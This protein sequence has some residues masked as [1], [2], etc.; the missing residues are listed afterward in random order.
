MMKRVGVALSTLG[1][2]LG[3]ASADPAVSGQESV[4]DSASRI[5]RADTED[6]PKAAVA[7]VGL[8]SLGGRR[9]CSGVYVAPRVVITAAHCL[10]DIVERTIVYFGADVTVD[11]DQFYNDDDSSKPWVVA[12]TWASHPDYDANLHF[13]DLAAVYLPRALPFEPAELLRSPLR[14]GDVDK[15]MTIS[16]WGASKALTPDLSELEGV[17]VQRT[18]KFPFLGSPTVNDF[19]PA[20][21][22]NGLF[23]PAIRARL[24]KFDGRAPESNSC[25]GDSGAPIFVKR[26]GKSYVAAINFFTGLSCEGYSMATRVEPFLRYFDDVIEKGGALAVEPKLRCVDQAADGTYTAFFGYENPNVIAVDIALGKNNKLRED[27]FG[28][29]PTRFL[30]GDHPWDFFLQFGRKERLEYEL[31]SGGDSC[32]ER[33]E[34]AVATSRSPRCDANAP[35]VSCAQLCK[36]LSACD[37]DF[38]DCMSDC[39]SNIPFF[40]QELPQCLAPWAA[41]NR[42]MA[43]LPTEDLCN[44]NSPPSCV[45]EMDAYN[46]CFE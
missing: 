15:D 14:N 20:D 26:G 38:G 45:T 2:A 1:C 33:H 17:G 8:T 41:L 29:R 6:G 40:Q 4:G 13:P 3:C 11:Q 32:R 34:R 35:D 12:E 43:A 18:A 19:V 46:A 7:V 37:L 36:G 25:A 30:P 44:F 10:T 24:A 23:V 21:P 42:C 22:N 28:V 9:Y 39:T 16:G 5:V 31:T 27:D